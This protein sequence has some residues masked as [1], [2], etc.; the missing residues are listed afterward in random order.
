MKIE[1]ELTNIKLYEGKEKK[2]AMLYEYS[3][4]TRELQKAVHLPIIDGF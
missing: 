3:T 1:Q 4:S 2:I